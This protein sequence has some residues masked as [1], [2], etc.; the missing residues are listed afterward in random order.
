MGNQ[1]GG[2]Q[3][4]YENAAKDTAKGLIKEGFDKLGVEVEKEVQAYE[5]TVTQRESVIANKRMEINQLKNN[6][7]TTKQKNIQTETSNLNYQKQ[8]EVSKSKISEKSQQLA[9]ISNQHK[10]KQLDNQNYVE[11]LTPKER[12][13]VLQKALDVKNHEIIQL[14]KNAELD[15]DFRNGD[16]I[17]LVQTALEVGH[18][19]IINKLKP[20]ASEESYHPPKKIIE[21]I[22]DLPLETNLINNLVL[23]LNHIEEIK[24]DVQSTGENIDSNL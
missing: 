14:F 7:N 20:L 23:H 1:L 24:D 18:H 21:T 19:E 6:V 15:A 9:E 3:Q 4:S 11:S 5:K 17:S 16:G 10:Q 12:S 13:F 22:A 8:L 2:M